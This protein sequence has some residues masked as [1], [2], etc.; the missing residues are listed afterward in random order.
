MP[1]GQSSHSSTSICDIYPNGYS[2]L[3]ELLVER[4]VGTDA[5]WQIT[6]E[7]SCLAKVADVGSTVMRVLF[8]GHSPVG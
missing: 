1:R 5:D 2:E 7:M 3:A 6:P 8:G 4:D